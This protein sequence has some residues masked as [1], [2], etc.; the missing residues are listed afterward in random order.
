MDPAGLAAEACIALRARPAPSRDRG[1][2]GSI[3]QPLRQGKRDDRQRLGHSE[4]IGSAEPHD[5]QIVIA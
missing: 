5:N 3:Y 1:H 4:V 2:A